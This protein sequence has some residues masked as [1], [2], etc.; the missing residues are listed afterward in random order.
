M[1]APPI[2]EGDFV[3]CAFPEHE[4]PLRP[5]PI[6]IGYTLAVSGAT[7]LSGF[8][9]A[10]VGYTT[11]Q[12]WPSDVRLPRGVFAFDREEA[13]NFGQPR[14]FVMDLRRIAYVPVTQTWFPR[15]GED[16]NGTLGHA[17]KAQQR[18]FRDTANDLIARHGESLDR[19][20][21]LWPGSRL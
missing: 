5:G 20:G 13:G 18:L 6:H 3:W 2:Q 11:S 17:P 16:G 4:A 19:L 14:A 8:P 7:S 10:L 15:L 1:T 12:P 9:S 21:P